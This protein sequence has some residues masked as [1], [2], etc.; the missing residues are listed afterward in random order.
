VPSCSFA[1]EQQLAIA[2]NELELIRRGAKE[3]GFLE[4]KALVNSARA[5]LNRILEE[6]KKE[7]GRKAVKPLAAF[8]AELDAQLEEISPKPRI[9]TE[10]LR[11]GTSVYVKALGSNA[12]V[13]TMD[14]RHKRLRL[15]A[16]SLELEVPFSAV[17]AAES[18]KQGVKSPRK[19]GSSDQTPL[20]Y[21][22]NLIG[23]RVEEALLA[24]DKFLDISLL[25]SLSEVRIIHGMG[26][27]NLMRGVREHLSRSP[28]VESFR[29]GESFEGRE[30]VTIVTM[31]N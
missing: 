14:S 6:A 7:K 24:L 3:K 21:E 27:G 28:H 22:L 13:L 10:S 15:R 29:S 5:E 17:S 11:P 20:S 31:R 1:R 16:G 9:D 25:N 4:A 12:T 30:G 8:E 26:T 2:H 19:L 18:S 23:W